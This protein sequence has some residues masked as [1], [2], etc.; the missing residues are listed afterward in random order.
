MAEIHLKLRTNDYHTGSDFMVLKLCLL[1]RAQDVRHIKS[2]SLYLSHYEIPLKS[3]CHS[4]YSLFA[5]SRSS[6]LSFYAFMFVC[7]C[8]FSFYSISAAHKSSTLHSI[9]VSSL[10]A[11]ISF[12]IP[13]ICVLQPIHILIYT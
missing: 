3:V 8:L 5:L 4:I 11:S 13:T 2:R 7:R 6:L 10:C 1:P 12:S 9:F